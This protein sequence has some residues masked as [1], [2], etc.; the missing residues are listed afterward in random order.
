MAIA[1]AT[2]KMRCFRLKWNLAHLSRIA[3]RAPTGTADTACVSKRSLCH[4]KD[5]NVSSEAAWDPA[6]HNRALANGPPT[7]RLDNLLATNRLGIPMVADWP[8]PRNL[9]RH[10]EQNPK[11]ECQ[12]DFPMDLTKILKHQFFQIWRWVE[13]FQVYLPKQTVMPTS[14]RDVTITVTGSIKNISTNIMVI[15]VGNNV[16][17]KTETHK[18]IRG[19]R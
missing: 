19:Y 18:W 4:N 17:D 8:K 16:Y 3:D 15:H 2:W 11:F 13:K 7:P 10:C 6:P 14:L 12:R 5:Q 9:Q 1:I